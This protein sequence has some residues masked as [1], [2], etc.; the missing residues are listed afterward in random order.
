MS[1]FFR[2]LLARPS[3]PSTHL[4]RYTERC[5]YFYIVLGLFLFFAPGAQVAIGLLPPFEGQEEGMYRL[6][7]MSLAFIGYFYVFGG[8][9]QSQVFGLATVLDRLVVPFFGLYVLQ[10]ST[11]EPMV[12]LP[13]CVLDPL[14]GLGAY[15]MWRKD[16][17]A[18]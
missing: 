12:M 8:R 6:I 11:I 15:W 17:A 2:A 14:L 1:Q 18:G 3:A 16:E 4:S 9:G 10:V 7:G 5:G 13:I